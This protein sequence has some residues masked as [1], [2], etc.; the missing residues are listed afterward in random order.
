[1]SSTKKKIIH[2]LLLILTALIWGVAFVAQSKGGDA[3]GPYTFNTVRSFIGGLSLIPVILVLDKMKLSPKKPKNKEE[4]KI[5]LKAGIICGVFL[6]IATNMQQLSIYLGASVGKAGFLTACYIVIVP[7]LGLFLHKKCGINIWIGVILTLVGLK[8]ICLSDGG[9]IKAVDLLLIICAF[10]FALQIIAIDKY[11]P[12]VDGVRLSVIQFLV[13]AVLGIIPTFIFDMNHSLSEFEVWIN[14]F[15]SVNVWIAILYAGIM[16]CAIGYTLQII[17]QEGLNPT[18]ASLLMSLE[19]VFSVIA[20]A[21]ILNEMLSTHEILG[22]ILI[23]IAII[24][25]QLP[26]KCRS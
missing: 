16:S 25:A 20:G 5:L 10:C 2:S 4:Q 26:V 8:M 6:F 15:A 12:Y 7:V 3:V 23:F 19:S 18:I 21:V 11:I 14:A 13:C 17:G 1:M 24:L 22:C 9:S